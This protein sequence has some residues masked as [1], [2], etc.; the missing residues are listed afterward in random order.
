MKN[1]PSSWTNR[2]TRVNPLNAPDAS[3]RCK[4]PNS[5]NLSGN[6]LY[7][8]SRESNMTQCPGQFIGLRAN[9]SSSVFSRNISSE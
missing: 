1:A 6:S 7:D 8:L 4:T 2:L 3:F 9:S 5:A